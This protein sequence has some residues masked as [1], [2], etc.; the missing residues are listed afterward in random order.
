MIVHGYSGVDGCQLLLAR[1][2][3]SN[4]RDGCSMPQRLDPKLSILPEPQREIWSDL[5]P[6]RRLNFVLY[7]GTAV[8]LH[9]GH[10]ESLD[11]DFFRSEPLDKDQV[12]AG[13]RFADRAAILQDTPDTLVVLAETPAG[14]VKV[15][16]FGG[17]SFGHV[18]DPLQ[19]SDGILLVASL[20][21]LLAT[22]LEA[23]LDRADAKDYRD[24]ARMI[25]TGTSL[26]TGLSAFRQMFNGEP[27]QVLRAI[28]YFEDGDLTTLS[29]ADRKVLSDA[30][31]HVC[32]LPEV[33]IRPGL[34]AGG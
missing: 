18:N 14:S 25:S 1:P 11:F 22:K 17:I 34:L 23:V 28:G 8:A 5:A 6:T 4:L 19:T 7:G 24:I 2:F 10:R 21:D 3:R 30:R 33:H 20:D 12:R 13:F 31:D 9:L 32:E 15:S 27:A 26:T 16:F 29:A